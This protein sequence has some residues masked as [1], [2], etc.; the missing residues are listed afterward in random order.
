MENAGENLTFY[1]DG[2][3]EIAGMMQAES[4]EEVREWVNGVIDEDSE[5]A[6]RVERVMH[7]ERFEQTAEEMMF[8]G[9]EDRY[10]IYHI[11]HDSKAKEYQFMGMDYVESQGMKVEASDYQCVYSGR[12]EE[13]DSLDSLYSMFNGNL[14]AD[15]KAHSL[16]TS[17]VIITNRGGEVQ[18]FYVDSFGYAELPEFVKQRQEILGIPSK[19]TITELLEQSACISFY[20]AECSEFPVLGECHH[21]LTLPEALKLYEKIPGE[22]MNGIKSVG[23]NLKDGSDYEGMFDLMAGDKVLRDVIDSIPYYKENALVQKALKDVEKYMGDKQQKIE[24][25]KSQHRRETLSL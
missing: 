10:S 12:L 4:W 24:K 20:V 22:R 2:T 9:S 18:A 3:H 15:Y 16:S 7:P 23:F 5:R 13:S 25:T 17:D 1:P 6:E 11:I 21:D 19:E 14:P 8:A